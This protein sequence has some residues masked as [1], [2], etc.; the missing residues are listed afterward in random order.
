MSSEEDKSDAVAPQI[1]NADAIHGYDDMGTKAHPGGERNEGH[2][3]N[4]A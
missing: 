2:C 3:G 4:H 1:I